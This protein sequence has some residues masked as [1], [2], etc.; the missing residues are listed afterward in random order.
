[1]PSFDIPSP[2]LRRATGALNAV[3]VRDVH[4]A[5]WPKSRL[6]MLYTA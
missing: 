3:N 2:G 5:A 4:I 6:I 1:M